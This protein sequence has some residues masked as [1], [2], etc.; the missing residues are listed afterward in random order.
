MALRF[1]EKKAVSV[2]MPTIK[3][4]A[5][6]AK[7]PAVVRDD[8]NQVKAS[9]LP[10]ASPKPSAEP[11]KNV[12]KPSGKAKQ[13]VT[14]RLSKGCVAFYAVQHGDEWRAKMQELLEQSVSDR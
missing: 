11:R 2:R 1:E 10:D 6:P 3:S 8:R 9:K 12:R 5:I 14:I 7:M 4:N 13:A